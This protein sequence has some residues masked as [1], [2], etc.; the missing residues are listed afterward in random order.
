MLTDMD[1]IEKCKDSHPHKVWV[2]ITVNEDFL[3]N[4]ESVDDWLKN[5]FVDGEYYYSFYHS[6]QWIWFHFKNEEDAAI[7][8]LTWT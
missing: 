4:F 6:Y 2:D 1:L 8:S 3:K 5:N 7:F